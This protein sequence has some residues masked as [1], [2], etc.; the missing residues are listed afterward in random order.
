MTSRE[1]VHAALNH[2]QPDRV[3][4][5][6]GGSR[7]TGIHVRAYQAL[8]DY[9]GLGGDPP[10][11]YD[12]MQML[13]LVDPEVLERLGIDVIPLHR[14]EII[15][16]L[17]VEQWQP[18]R[19]WDGT[20]VQV[21]AG[22]SPKT[23]PNGDLLIYHEGRPVARMPKGG[24]FFDSVPEAI[25]AKVPPEAFHPPLLTDEELQWMQ[26][27]ARQLHRDTDKAILGGLYIGNLFEIYLGGFEEWMVT[28]HTDPAY[29][30]AIYERL[31]E[32]WIANLKLYDE[33]VGPYICAVVFCDDLGTQRGEWVRRDLFEE[34][35][36]PYYR[37]VFGWMHEHTRLKVFLHSC[38]SI[39]N[40]LPVLVDVGVDILNPVQC[41]AA[42]MDPL[43]LKREF[44]DQLVFWGGGVDT[45][46]VLPFGTPDEVRAQ[47]RERLDIFAPGGGFVFNTVHNILPEVP[48][49]NL[50]AMVETV[51]AWPG[52]P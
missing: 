45:Q 21:P 20:P 1:R 7:V 29:V 46:H 19:L 12:V 9:L 17:G 37:R 18:W 52:T 40:L 2:Q 26:D 15:W 22:F 13:A 8:R 31:T 50:V 4:L 35:V 10:R 49:E 3:P 23:Q 39:W 24:D 42:G 43:A 25:A 33:A 5:D 14:R 51:H 47:T 28:L 6:I 27:Q 34:R 36:A 16:G 48:P 11:V 44:G 32:N 38:G 30:H 41:S